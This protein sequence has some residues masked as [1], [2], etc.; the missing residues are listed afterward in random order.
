MQFEIELKSKFS[1][2]SQWLALLRLPYASTDL[3]QSS[4]SF[5]HRIISHSP[6]F[7]LD[8]IF[9]QGQLSWIFLRKIVDGPEFRTP[10]VV[11]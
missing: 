3:P 8:L 4:L 10:F 2:F 5:D 1:Y 6:N 9:S 11:C 7:L